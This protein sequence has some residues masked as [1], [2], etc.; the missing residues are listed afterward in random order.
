MASAI[1]LL[2]LSTQAS[3][4]G[5]YSGGITFS[6][7]GGLSAVE[8]TIKGATDKLA[9]QHPELQPHERTVHNQAYGRQDRIDFTVQNR[10]DF[11]K[12]VTTFILYEG[13]R[14]ESIACP[15]GSEQ[16]RGDF[17]YIIDPNDGPCA[18]N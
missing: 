3:A 9:T 7:F 11:P 6:D 12:T 10:L 2:C 18:R 13:F 4:Y 8:A 17:F 1:A 15:H 5:C 16:D 14:A